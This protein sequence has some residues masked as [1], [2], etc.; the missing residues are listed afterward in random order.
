MRSAASVEQLGLQTK[1]SVKFVKF[2]Q[3]SSKDFQ[4]NKIFL[5]HLAKKTH[6][7]PKT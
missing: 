1:T 3:I 6:I 7:S 5:K 2:V 4:K